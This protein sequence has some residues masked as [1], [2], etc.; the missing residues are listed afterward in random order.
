MIYKKRSL[1]KHR[2]VFLHL[3]DYLFPI[4]RVH[5][6]AEAL[7]K[8]GYAVN[9][10]CVAEKSKDALQRIIN[11][12]SIWNAGYGLKINEHIK[13]SRRI[14]LLAKIKKNM[15][16]LCAQLNPDAIHVFSPELLPLG[17]KLKRKLNTLLLYDC[18]EYW[19][20]GKM[21]DKKPL[22]ALRTFFMELYGLHYI[23]AITIV[24]G[25]NPVLNFLKQNTQKCIVYNTRN[26]QDLKDSEMPIDIK[27]FKKNKKFIV[28]YI[29][30]IFKIRG[31]IDAVKSLHYLDNDIILMLIGGFRNKKF[32]NKLLKS[33]EKESLENR[34]Y[35]TGKLPYNEVLHYGSATD[36]CLL[37]FEDKLINKYSTPNKLFEY[38]GLGKPIISTNIE[39]L[40]YFIDKYKCGITVPPKNP[41]A[42]AEAILKLKKNK[43]LLEE[44]GSNGKDAFI[45]H[46]SVEKQTKNLIQLYQSLL[47]I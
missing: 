16:R 8:E 20:G 24:Y 18:Y 43:E 15:E 11:G 14:Y 17:V 30:L 29:G 1:E 46:F 36:V 26:E 47:P 39:N 21:S 27:D 10:I 9:V 4:P 23:D 12:V 45:K 7:V 6:M 32:K 33:I 3:Q 31:Y 2:V 34:V 42:I 41:L 38:M 25:K 28:G 5:Y 37:L 13:L 40:K 44:F 19:F 35:I 22:R